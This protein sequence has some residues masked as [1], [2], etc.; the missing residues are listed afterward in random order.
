[1]PGWRGQP[2]EGRTMHEKK[3][4]PAQAE[5]TSKRPN[6][7]DTSAANQ[8][9]ITIQALR[10]G[11]QTTVQLRECY[12]ILSPAPR[13]LELRERGFS[14]LTQR[15]KVQTPDGVMHF[16]VARYVLLSESEVGA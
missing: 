13:V 4:A 16:A 12:G 10:T 3:A 15:V 14:I 5:A 6:R 7:N 11:P 1:M 8:R 9:A 2:L